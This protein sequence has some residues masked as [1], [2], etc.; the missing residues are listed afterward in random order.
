MGRLQNAIRALFQGD[1]KPSRKSNQNHLRFLQA[2]AQGRLESSWIN[3]PSTPGALINQHWLTLVSRSREQVL[4][5]DYARKFI[6]MVRENVAGQSGFKLNVQ[7]TDLDGTPDYV[8]SNA[9]EEAWE[10]WGKIGN[11]EVTGL[12]SRS[13]GDRLAVSTVAQDGDCF[14]A[15]LMGPEFGKWGFQLQFIDAIHL[16]HDHFET[17]TNGNEI[18][19]GIEYNQYGKPIAY[20][21]QEN[22]GGDDRFA[23]VG[24]TN[25]FKTKR[26][27]AENV[28]HLFLPGMVNQK[29][30]LP[31]MTTAIWKMRMLSGF[32][33]A[34][35]TNA[36]IGAAKMGFFKSTG[37]DTDPDDEK[38]I[39]MD[40]EAG[41][42]EDIGNRDFV[43]F[44]P[45]FPDA[46]YEPFVKSL[47]RS[48]AS[49]LGVSYNNLA[50]DL[51][52]VSFSSIR[53]GALD[54]RE[55]W[56]GLQEWQMQ[57]WC[58]KIYNK[59]IEYQVATGKIKINGTPL[60]VYQLDKYKKVSFRA[61]RWSWIDPQSEMTAYEKSIGNGLKSRTEIIEEMGRDPEDVWQ[62]IARETKTMN[63]LGV[64]P[65]VPNSF[66][67]NLP[68]DQILKPAQEN[69]PPA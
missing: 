46:M 34:A 36:R 35:I 5:N 24:V 14:A 59:W 64:K 8:A 48:I 61:R 13:A 55:V 27:L 45:R 49:G 23:N 32:E 44:D 11:Y 3:F 57:N 37:E 25:S 15:I 67:G 30:G 68:A 69:N 41:T 52:S 18:R 51:T 26:I 58:E 43:A 38:P 21:F 4:N 19:H 1:Q 6:S 7:I 20:Y 12:F 56:K 2:G 40:C 39:P 31:W 54:E 66:M 60:R 50:N 62:E 10:D 47:L 17:L 42:F 22:S 28:I 9:I 33:D 65:L 29:R 16:K 53:Q 63:G